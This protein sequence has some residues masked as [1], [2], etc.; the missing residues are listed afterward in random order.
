MET[1]RV[2]DLNELYLVDGGKKTV[3]DYLILGGALCCI[4]LNP[5]VGAALTVAVF[6]LT[7]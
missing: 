4:P 5:Y 7:D 3:S 2:L 1:L 6:T